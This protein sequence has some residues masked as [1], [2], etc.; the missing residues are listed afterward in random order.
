MLPL[1]VFSW[2]LVFGADPAEAPRYAIRCSKILTVDES[3]T[4]L[5]N[6]VLLVSSGRIEALGE[7]RSLGVPEGYTAIEVPTLWAAPGLIDF[8]DHIAGSL[9]DLNDGVYLSNPGL[10]ALDTVEPDNDNL[11]KA[12][13]G[14]VTT[15]LLIPGSG[16]NISGFGVFVKTAGDSIHEMLVRH[17]GSLKIA[18]SGNPERYWYGVARS[19]MNWNTRD[20]LLRARAYHESWRAYEDGR[21]EKPELNPYFHEFRGLFDK[22]FPTS[23]HTQIYQV[24]AETIQMQHDELGLWV[25]TDHSEIGG[26]PLGRETARRGMF[27][28]QGPRQLHFERRD[29]K[30]YGDAGMW[31]A[32]GEGKQKLG[33]NTDAPVIPQEELSYQATMAVHFGLP[34]EY[35]MV[36]VT[37]LPAQAAG[38]YDRIGS[39]EVGKDADIGLWTGDPIDPQSACLMLLVNGRIAYDS[40][41]MGRR[42]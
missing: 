38:L 10:R 30:I 31:Y 23:V 17:P 2:S 33:V 37:R 15:V 25:V 6:A 32:L 18:Q 26:F 34:R 35:A 8:H 9:M 41:T 7:Q 1:I 24:V 39:L 5:N 13:A 21:G 20:T 12:R 11:L 27:V 22:K 42:F 29:R 40:K 28:V 16:N 19:F 36:A 3:N 4:V 14:G